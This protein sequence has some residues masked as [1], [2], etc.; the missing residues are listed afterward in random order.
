MKIVDLFREFD[1]S[2]PTDTVRTLPDGE[3]RY[4]LEIPVEHS[5]E[6][7]LNGI[8][9]M[10]LVC[11]PSDLPEL[12]LGRLL[13]EGM[14]VGGGDVE[15]IYICQYGSRA[16]VTLNKT[17]AAEKK[18][19]TEVIPSCCTGNRVL[20]DMFTREEPPVKVAPIP[21]KRKWIFALAERFQQG[22]PIHTAT[23]GTHSCFLAVEGE[24][25]YTC[26]DIGRH[27]ALD[28]VIGH[29]IRDGV[30]LRRAILFTSGRVP[31]DMTL[32]AI[33]AGVPVLASKTVPTDRAVE[34][35]REYGLT[36]ICSARRD[37]LTVYAGTAPT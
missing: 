4:S 29:A 20:N 31:V 34:L 35:A 26:E 25:L 23:G 14:I 3:E 32:K 1:C 17:P 24:C 11:S 36:L 15:S 27:N 6:V 12:V 21:L 16:Q 22:T 19:F 9:T 7:Y 37:R 18:P 8:L 10:K 33:R 2:V 13:T 5:L 28:K 30:E